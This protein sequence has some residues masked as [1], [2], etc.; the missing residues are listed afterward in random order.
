MSF[1]HRIHPLFHNF[2]QLNKVTEANYPHD[3]EQ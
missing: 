1:P 2:Y 3:E